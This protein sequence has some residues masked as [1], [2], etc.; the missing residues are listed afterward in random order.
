MKISKVLKMKD[1]KQAEFEL[2]LTHEA[3]QLLINGQQAIIFTA[4]KEASL[5]GCLGNVV[6]FKQTKHEELAFEDWRIE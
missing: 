1:G 5:I 2:I 6:P 4:Y 3:I